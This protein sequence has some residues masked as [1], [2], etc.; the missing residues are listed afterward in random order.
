MLGNALLAIALLTQGT[1]EGAVAGIF[2]TND[3]SIPFRYQQLGSRLRQEYTVENMTVVSIYDGTTGDLITIMPQ[4]KQYM[5]MNM[6]TASGPMRGLAG[7]GRGKTPDL[8]KT[9]VTDL[10]RQETIAGRRCNHY[11]FE[12][13]EAE[14][15]SKMDICGASGLGFMGMPGDV[16]GAMPSTIQLLRSQ[17][18]ALMKLAR[19]GFFPLR[20][21]VMNKKNH[22]IEWEVTQLDLRRPDAA[23]FQPPAGYQPMAV[24][25]MSGKP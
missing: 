17:N 8:S 15:Q 5:I 13:V 22:N 1:F 10:G 18:P 2:K 19:E 7:G 9:K 23:L 3:K 11:L 25:G 21:T 12:N 6:R 14:D 4:R 16:N 24:P 20:M